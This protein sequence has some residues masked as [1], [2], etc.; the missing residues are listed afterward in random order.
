MKKT[1]KI[2][3]YRQ[4]INLL[5]PQNKILKRDNLGK[6]DLKESRTKLGLEETV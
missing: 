4:L 5:G 1:Q 6:A 3:I 2:N